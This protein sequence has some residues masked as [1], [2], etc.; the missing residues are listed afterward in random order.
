MKVPRSQRRCLDDLVCL[1]T[2]RCKW[3]VRL[4]ASAG[5]DLAYGLGERLNLHRDLGC[6][7]CEHGGWIGCEHCFVSLEKWQECLEQYRPTLRLCLAMLCHQLFIEHVTKRPQQGP[8][9]LER[10]CQAKAPDGED[11]I[12]SYPRQR[13]S[14][15]DRGK[16]LEQDYCKAFEVHAISLVPARALPSPCR[17]LADE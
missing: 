3:L 1:L 10:N 8:G 5:F 6:R 15:I 16:A 4:W 17:R 14:Y 2:W 9:Q 7:G 12:T 11:E 13:Y